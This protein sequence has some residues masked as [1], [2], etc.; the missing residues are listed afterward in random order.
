M[1]RNITKRVRLFLITLLVV[2][3]GCAAVPA[4]E[5]SDARQALRAAQDSGAM[6][7]APAMMAKAERLM[8]KA[9]RSL[10]AGEYRAARKNAEEARSLAIEA[11]QMTVRGK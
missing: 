7:S 5:M 1:S 6:E 8:Q 11:R 2:V 4:Q 9:E 3:A 10:E